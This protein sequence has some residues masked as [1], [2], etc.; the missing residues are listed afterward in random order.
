MRDEHAAD[1]HD[2]DVTNTN[3]G[4]PLDLE[5]FSAAQQRPQTFSGRGHPHRAAGWQRTKQSLVARLVQSAES[6]YLMPAGVMLR[7]LAV[8]FTLP[9]C[10]RNALATFGAEY[11][12]PCFAQNFDVMPLVTSISPAT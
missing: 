5:R 12:T 8:R 4:D 7:P 3:G 9:G 11:F 1:H 2:R 6:T 10:V